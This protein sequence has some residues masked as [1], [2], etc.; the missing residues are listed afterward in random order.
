MRLN[1]RKNKG[2]VR[3]WTVTATLFFSRGNPGS[4]LFLFWSVHLS[5][6][7]RLS[8]APTDVDWLI[9]GYIFRMVQPT[10]IYGSIF[11]S[12]HHFSLY[13]G[14]PWIYI[15]TDILPNT[16]QQGERKSFERVLETQRKECSLD[17][18]TLFSSTLCEVDL[19]TD[20]FEARASFPCLQRPQLDTHPW[21]PWTWTRMIPCLLRDSPCLRLRTLRTTSH[22][23][24]RLVNRVLCARLVHRLHSNSDPPLP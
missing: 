19:R 15:P 20:C 22:S 6:F 17:R 13:G 4:F 23:C 14:Y 21:S 10:Y 18:I 5:T 2:K 12:K 8:R 1:P 9:M 7:S 3:F 11:H 24:R 16:T